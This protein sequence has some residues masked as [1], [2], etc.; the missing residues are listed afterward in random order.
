MDDHVTRV[1]S[2]MDGPDL[3]RGFQGGLTRSPVHGNA[4]IPTPDASIS[5][6][7][8]TNGR[9]RSSR[10]FSYRNSRSLVL[11]TPDFTN[12]DI[13]MICRDFCLAL[14]EV[15]PRALLSDLTADGISE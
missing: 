8:S 14:E 6:R 5:P 7:V 13:P 15:K 2:Q 12:A 10:D 4:D 9:S 3:C 11:V 1:L